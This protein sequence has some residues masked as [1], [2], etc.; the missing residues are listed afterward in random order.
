MTRTERTIVLHW[1]GIAILCAIVCPVR[2]L[3][4]HMA[5]RRRLDRVEADQ[6]YAAATAEA[7]LRGKAV[8]TLAGDV[9]ALRQQVEGQGRHRWH[10]T[11]RRPWTTC[12]SGPKYR[13]RSRA[14]RGQRV[15]AG[16]SGFAGKRLAAQVRAALLGWARPGLPA[17]TVRPGPRVSLVRLVLR[18]RRAPP[19]LRV[20]TGGTVRRARTVI[21]CRRRPTIRMRWCAGRMVL[22][23]RAGHRGLSRV[24][25]WWRCGVRS[26]G[27]TPKQLR[28]SRVVRPPPT[29]RTGPPA[30]SAPRQ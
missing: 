29:P 14:R 11:R 12:R 5:P 20:R 6:R 25:P 27:S 28:R 21:R 19:G 23:S 30:A 1:R 15:S 17:P 3:M 18:A 4:G 2:H 8:S 22:R 26:D 24:R 13:C 10:R 9:R 16:A 7:D